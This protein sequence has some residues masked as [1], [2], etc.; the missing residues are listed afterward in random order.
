MIVSSCLQ[1]A[2]SIT[3]SRYLLATSRMWSVKHL[4]PQI[5]DRTGNRLLVGAQVGGGRVSNIDGD[6]A[7]AAGSKAE[8]VELDRTRVPK[9]DNRLYL[10]G[11][12]RSNF[13]TKPTSRGALQ[14]S[15]HEVRFQ[16]LYGSNCRPVPTEYAIA[17]RRVLEASWNRTQVRVPT[18]VRFQPPPQELEENASLAV[19]NPNVAAN[20]IVW[21]T[22]PPSGL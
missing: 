15:W 19:S 2:V 20:T 11:S 18:R 13:G 10:R 5:L 3:S 17:S 1:L 6:V 7:E 14:T 9:V 12:N 8:F 21:Q 16:P 4:P 22:T